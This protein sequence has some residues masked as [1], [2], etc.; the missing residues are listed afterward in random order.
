VGNSRF[1]LDLHVSKGYFVDTPGEVIYNIM[2][3]VDRGDAQPQRPGS[4]LTFGY[5][6]KIDED[7]G[8]EIVLQA[9]T[10]IKRADWK[11]KIAGRGTEQ[12]VAKLRR[13]FADPRI[14]W[15]GFTAVH[16]IMNQIDVTIVPS[17]WYEPLPRVLIESI[18]YRRPTI[19]STSGGIPEISH[20]ADLIGEYEPTD[21]DALARL[22]ERAVS[23]RRFARTYRDE[24]ATNL[25]QL[26]GAPIV[27]DR[28]VAV[29]RAALSKRSLETV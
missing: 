17:V 15:L 6:G 2:E 14:E 26:F 7:K 13:T 10:R 16:D 27:A 25:P 4:T 11:L 24:R 5:L 28:N 19:C 18:A 1:L 21:T 29:Y 3:T 23:E 8:I 12:Y 22:M 20:Y 9:T